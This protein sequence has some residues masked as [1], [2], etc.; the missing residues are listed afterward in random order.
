MSER[1]NL[2]EGAASPDS[3]RFRHPTVS[4]IVEHDVFLIMS[5][6]FVGHPPLPPSMGFLHSSGAYQMEWE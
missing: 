4:A 6:R 2:L 5:S 1:S 3:L